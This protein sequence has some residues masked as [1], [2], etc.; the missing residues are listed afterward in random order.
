MTP[1]VLPGNQP[2][3]ALLPARILS[4]TDASRPSIHSSIPEPIDDQPEE[5]ARHH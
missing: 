1:E 2:D 3:D 4:P 5:Y